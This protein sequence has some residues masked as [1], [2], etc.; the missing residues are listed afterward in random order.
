MWREKWLSNLVR[1]SSY[2]FSGNQRKYFLGIKEAMSLVAKRVMGEPKY[3]STLKSKVHKTFLKNY[4]QDRNGGY[5]YPSASLLWGDNILRWFSNLP[6]SKYLL[7]SYRNKE[8]KQNTIGSNY[9]TDS[10]DVNLSELRE[11]VM[12]REAC[13]AAVRGVAKSRTQLS[14]WT[15]LNLKKAGASQVAQIVKYFPEMRE[16]WLRSLG[17][18]DPLEKGMATHSSVLAWRIPW[19][20]EPGGIQSTG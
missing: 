16:I 6:K 18:E 13:H 8:N 11:L 7:W 1:G 12:G 15:E 5:S 9:I 3:I 20:E 17:Q 10:M 14:D 2:L 4:I 19:T